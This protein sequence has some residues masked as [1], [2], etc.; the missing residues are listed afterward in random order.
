MNLAMLTLIACSGK[1]DGNDKEDGVDSSAD[2]GDSAVDDTGD[3]GDSTV[4]SG[5]SGDSTVDSGDTATMSC[6]E[7]VVGSEDTFNISNETELANAIECFQSTYTTSETLVL[8][9]QTDI[10]ATA[11]FT[12]LNVKVLGNTYHWTSNDATEGSAIIDS[13]GGSLTVE[14]LTLVGENQSIG[15]YATDAAVLTVTNTSMTQVIGAGIF[16]EGL[17]V[18]D[19]ED[20]NFADLSAGVVAAI[21]ADGASSV[22]VHGMTITAA[23]SQLALEIDADTIALS[24][25]RIDGEDAV[26]KTNNFV[27]GG[28][29]L[30]STST[31]TVDGLYFVDSDLGNGNV[32]SFSGTG[33]AYVRNTTLA[34]LSAVDTAYSGPMIVSNGVNFDVDMSEFASGTSYVG[35][36]TFDGD[37]GLELP[38]GSAQMDDAAGTLAFT[39]ANGFDY[40]VDYTTSGS[41]SDVTN[42][43]ASDPDAGDRGAHSG[44]GLTD[45]LTQ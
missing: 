20:V 24:G 14:N 37:F 22:D 2:T 27:L 42:G 17:S 28:L 18:V 1:N 3:S 44:R 10:I 15:I 39:T 9:L 19:V 45:L 11:T 32:V 7:T 23:T 13:F 21:V 6:G 41:A 43:I 8:S 40:E 12:G 34:E 4:D 31:T 35:Y 30:S 36:Q 16:A 33:T 38:E 25:V 29:A 5:D 26:T